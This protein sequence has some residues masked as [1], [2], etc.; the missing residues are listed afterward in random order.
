MQGDYV[1]MFELFHKGDFAD[2]GARGA[3]FA[4]EVDFF[5]GNELACLTVAAFEDLVVGS[6]F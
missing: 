5:Q 1:V 3:F 6:K 2:R 4:V